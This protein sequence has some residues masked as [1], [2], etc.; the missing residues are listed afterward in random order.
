MRVCV[1]GLEPRTVRFVAERTHTSIK[2][3]YVYHATFI[4]VLFPAASTRT[5]TSVSLSLLLTL[6]IVPPSDCVHLVHTRA[7]FFPSLDGSSPGNFGLMDCVASLHWIQENIGEFGGDPSNV[8]TIQHLNWRECVIEPVLSAVFSMQV[9][10]Y[11]HGQ[12]AA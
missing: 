11:G 5:L 10:I 6:D 9:T 4:V 3:A 12:G 1:C 2:S 7:G 8:R